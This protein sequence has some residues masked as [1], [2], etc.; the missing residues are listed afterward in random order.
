MKLNNNL[1]KYWLAVS[2]LIVS[3]CELTSE[4]E[5][6]PHIQQELNSVLTAFS[7]TQ[8]IEQTT[9]PDGFEQ[10]LLSSVGVNL[11]L[12]K[13]FELTR[14]D[15]NA[16]KVSV[17]EFVGLVADTPY[18]VALN[19]EISGEILLTLKGVTMDE[20]IK[21]VSSLYGFDMFRE[22]KVVQVLPAKMRTESIPVNYLMMKRSGLS[23]AHRAKPAVAAQAMQA[24]RHGGLDNILDWFE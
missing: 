8:A 10:E 3:G 2:V 7:A 11:S 20:V 6:K 21:I 17:N 15:V 24:I 5:L 23:V 16:N 1:F 13:E 19:P 14:F 4:P 18:S 22:G 12:P 9:T